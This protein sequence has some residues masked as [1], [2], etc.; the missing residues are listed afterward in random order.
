MILAELIKIY[1]DAFLELL[2]QRKELRLKLLAFLG[3][4]GRRNPQF[5]HKTG[6]YIVCDLFEKCSAR[7]LAR[8]DL[9]NAFVPVF[10]MLGC[11]ETLLPAPVITGSLFVDP[12]SAALLDQEDKPTTRARWRRCSGTYYAPT[13]RGQ[14]RPAARTC[15]RK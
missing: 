7:R 11:Y 9:L 3:A 2:H 10:A 4:D 1:K 5:V 8:E 15:P 12:A 13:D 6:V 14:R